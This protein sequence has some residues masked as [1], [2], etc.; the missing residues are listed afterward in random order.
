M[1]SDLRMLM[2]PTSEQRSEKRQC[3]NSRQIESYVPVNTI[4]PSL[5]E[6]IIASSQVP[7]S[8]QCMIDL[9]DSTNI[10]LTELVFKT[11]PDIVLNQ[12]KS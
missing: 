8:F 11:I 9:N 6:P 12:F 10:I 3:K 2:N 7:N 4:C 5:P 1:W